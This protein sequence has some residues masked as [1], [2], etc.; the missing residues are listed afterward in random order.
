MESEGIIY[1]LTNPAMPGMLKIGM[2]TREEIEVRMNELH[3]TGVPL[4]FECSFAGKTNNLKKVEKALHIAFG[5]QRVNPKR[6]FFEIEDIQV[7]ELLKLLCSEDVTPEV[8]I[9]LEKVDEVSKN[10]GK[11]FKEKRPKLNFNEMKIPIG[12]KIFSASN[13]DFCLITS[14]NKVSYNNEEMSLTKATKLSL[15]NNYNIAP[16][17]QWNYLGE[18]LSEIYDKTYGNFE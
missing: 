11:R 15:G 6:E 12:E 5:P 7:I 8:N 10:A 1:V 3:T 17:P 18:N 2:T 16:C 13:E 14:K 9:E 4:P